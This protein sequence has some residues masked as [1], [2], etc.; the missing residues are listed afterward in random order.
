MR[1]PVN[2]D[3]R[4]LPPGWNQHYDAQRRKWYY[5]C[6][7]V[8]PPHVST[9]HPLGPIV[10]PTPLPPI[11]ASPSPSP[12]VY[13]LGMPEPGSPVSSVSS[14]TSSLP[15]AD[16]PRP[17]SPIQ[18]RAS[19]LTFAQQLYASAIQPDDRVS[20]PLTETGGL[21]SPP[22]SPSAAIPRTVP[23]LSTPSSSFTISSTSQQDVSDPTELYSTRVSSQYIQPRNKTR[24]ASSYFSSSSPFPDPTA[25][26]AA[27]RTQ[28]HQ[29]VSSSYQQTYSPH[30]AS[31][32]MGK[33]S[34]P[35]GTPNLLTTLRP[36]RSQFGNK[37]DSTPSFQTIAAPPPPSL[38]LQQTGLQNTGTIA[39]P[40][41]SYPSPPVSN[42]SPLSAF[43]LQASYNL[44][45]SAQAPQLP[46]SVLNAQTSYN[47]PAGAHTPQLSTSTLNHQASYNIPASAQPP[48]PPTSTLNPALYT[49][50]AGAQ[51]L[52]PATGV[53]TAPPSQ[54]FTG[55]NVSQ[56]LPTHSS[57]PNSHP[58]LSQL[59]PAA[60]EVGKKLGGFALKVAGGAL[61]A[62]AGVSEDVVGDL[63]GLGGAIGGALVN[64]S[65]DS[66][67][68][69]MSSLVGGLA[70]LAT[71]PGV[72]H[73]LV[74]A[75]MQ[76]KPGADYQA[77]INAL[78][79]QQAQPTPGVNYQ[80]L[81]LQLQQMQ[82]L[83]NAQQQ[84]AIAQLPNM[85]SIYNANAQ[86]QAIT[87]ASQQ[88]AAQAQQ[89][90]NLVQAA[91]QQQL[92]AQ[93]QQQIQQQIQQQLQAQEQQRQQVQLQIE[94]QLQAQQ[95]QAQLM[96]G[97]PPQ[98]TPMGTFLTGA[99]QALASYA[100][101]NNGD[102][103][104]SYNPEL[105]DGY[106]YY[107]EGSW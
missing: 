57:P 5:V 6:T 85:Q 13:A 17:R 51:A 2:P 35:Y 16:E 66:G 54:N 8:K 37:V 89:N 24:R 49:L 68:L 100:A 18:P 3:T 55:Q 82:A 73:S 11:S 74:Q 65:S 79:K 53:M 94:Q 56:N 52:Q 15:I 83:A 20:P 48:Q 36:P 38:Q 90:Q 67:D 64:G 28:S 23:I 96:F 62:S 93:Q 86:A 60:I 58:H 10:A 33:S 104:S 76:G 21:P 95:Q 81:I 46:A 107:G 43:S 4:P 71:Q 45:A 42:P 70:K 103:A 7:N 22:L 1:V 91:Y 78:T 14:H 32:Y 106:S 77:L 30:R 87:N 59:K 105:V 72:D 92:Q 26:P 19:G 41:P 34:T 99:G 25:P 98:L 40:V 84:Q 9:D 101:S 102:A 69:I 61:A 47:L 80:A 27:R 12:P 50:P 88:I 97:Q 63:G 31:T 44:P 75:A 29:P 39:A